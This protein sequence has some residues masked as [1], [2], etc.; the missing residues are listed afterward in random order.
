MSAPIEKKCTKQNH[1]LQTFLPRGG[2]VGLWAGRHANGLSCNA[3]MC[4]A[5]KQYLKC[6]IWKL[7]NGMQQAVH[8]ARDNAFPRPLRLVYHRCWLAGSTRLVNLNHNRAV[9]IMNLPVFCIIC[10][11]ID[12]WTFFYVFV[13]QTD[14]FVVHLRPM[15]C[16]TGFP[17]VSLRCWGHRWLA[18]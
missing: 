14:F 5:Q 10:F 1:L 2:R 18:G 13:F 17:W 7:K 9:S 8:H 11:H 12:F 16:L 15:L 4:G 6:A 3:T